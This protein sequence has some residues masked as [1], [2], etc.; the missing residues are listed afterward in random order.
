MD[1]MST[2]ERPIDGAA[3][4][5]LYETV[6]WWPTRS[7]DEVLAVLARGPAVGAWDGDDLV[8]FARAVSDGSFRAYVEDVVVRDDHRGR[9][10]ALRMLEVLLALLSDID[11]V[12]LF[13][14]NELVSL[15]EK[16]GFASTN[17]AVMHR[18]N[19]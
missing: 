14:G 4:V 5:R 6:A 18:N 16:V 12:S 11:I 19:A 3:V 15:Y 1:V 2:L 10:T 17:Q 7:A 9:G 13:C 8:G